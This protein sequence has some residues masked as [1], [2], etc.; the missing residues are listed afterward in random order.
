M[1]YPTP[2]RCCVL[3]NKFSSLHVSTPTFVLLTL[4]ADDD[5]REGCRRCKCQPTWHLT[6]H[7]RNIPFT[8]HVEGFGWCEV[9]CEHL[10]ASD[11]FL[12]I[13]GVHSV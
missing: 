3:C 8:S 7:T 2:S 6:Q 12:D 9:V 11:K 4:G 13:R 10:T 1:A 5:K